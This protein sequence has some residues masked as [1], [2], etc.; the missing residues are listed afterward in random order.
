MTEDAVPDGHVRLR[1]AAASLCGTDLHYY[2]D[3]SNAGFELK[4]PVTLGHE[5]CAWVEEPNGSNLK[6]GQLVALNPVMN[7]Q[8][9]AACRSSEENL[10][11]AKKFPGS[12]TTVPHIDGFFREIFEHP[13]RCCRPVKSGVNPHHLTFAE[14]LSC[15]LHALNKAEIR[16]GYSALVTGCGP[17]GLLTIAAAAARGARVTA[18]DLRPAAV[19]AAISADAETG[20]VATDLDEAALDTTFDRAI[21]AS[22]AVVAFNTALKALRQQGR[23][24]ILSF[25]Q[26]SA[27][28]ASFNMIT[29]KEIEV[30]GSFQ[31]NREFD[32]AVR[33][34]KSGTIDFDALTSRRCPLAETAEALAFM[35]SGEAYGKVVLTGA[36]APIQ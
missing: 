20:I 2:S 25:I 26:P 3:F 15:A 33:F 30:V 1:L 6:T 9:C 11:C 22:G 17:M 19:N 7:C 28:A 23:L 32:E 10:C 14:P 5:A 36:D 34:V 24:S 12:A 31:F 16:E 4:T 8:E 35:A 13:A 21:E 27:M 18:I 29:L